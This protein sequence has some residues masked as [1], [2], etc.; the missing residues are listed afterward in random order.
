VANNDLSG[1]SAGLVVFAVQVLP[2][3]RGIRQSF[4][5]VFT[6]VKKGRIPPIE[7]RIPAVGQKADPAHRGRNVISCPQAG[8]VPAAGPI[9]RQ[10]V[11]TAFFVSLCLYSQSAGISFSTAMDIKLTCQP[12]C[13][14]DREDQ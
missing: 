7:R 12:C 9:V 4:T 8:A 11:P 5:P 2:R 6:P 14:N 13:P 3:P 1:D 10:N